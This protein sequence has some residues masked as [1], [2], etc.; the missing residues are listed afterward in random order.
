MLSAICN[1]T[2]AWAAVH[3][4]CFSLYIHSLKDFVFQAHLQE[5]NDTR[6]ALVSQVAMLLHLHRTTLRLVHFESLSCTVAPMVITTDDEFL[7]GLVDTA[8]A[9]QQAVREYQVML[10]YTVACG[11]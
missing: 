11:V 4:V 9:A 6:A 1:R 2:V 8:A 10:C 5:I 7:R 3:I